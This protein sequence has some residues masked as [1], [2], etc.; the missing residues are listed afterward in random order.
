MATNYRECEM[1]INN[2]HGKEGTTTCVAVDGRQLEMDFSSTAEGSFK[3]VYLNEKTGYLNKTYVVSNG[4]IDV[5]LEREINIQRKLSN[6]GVVPRIIGSP[7][8]YK[9]AEGDS[10]IQVISENAITSNTTSTMTGVHNKR[11]FNL[12][13][14]H[15]VVSNPDYFKAVN[16]QIKEFVLFN[17]HIIFRQYRKNAKKMHS[18]LAELRMGALFFAS[19]PVNLAKDWCLGLPPIVSAFKSMKKIHDKGYVHCDLKA[20]NMFYDTATK[21]VTIID[22][23]LSHDLKEY[24]RM[25]DE[26]LL[27][28]KS[29]ECKYTAVIKP[30]IKEIVSLIKTR[31]K[32]INPFIFREGF[33]LY[34]GN[35]YGLLFAHT[36]FYGVNHKQLSNVRKNL[37]LLEKVITTSGASAEAIMQNIRGLYH[38]TSLYLDMLE[39]ISQAYE[40]VVGR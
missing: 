18:K 4:E 23:G 33:V 38:N 39:G 34:D 15:L 17:A 13:A 35:A 26:Y 40:A 3:K 6:T 25:F 29:P 8:K 36:L 22:F 20:D 30:V 27:S 12:A 37:V 1:R 14:P 28:I 7:V 24:D 19:D 11:T 21:K 32:R 5:N 9:T 16:V 2:K 10:C 31:R